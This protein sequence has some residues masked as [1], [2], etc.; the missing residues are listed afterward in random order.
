MAK[1]AFL[2]LGKGLFNE[3]SNKLLQ[4]GKE[5]LI[6]SGNEMVEKGKDVLMEEVNEKISNLSG[7]L[8]GEKSKEKS[9]SSLS[10][11]LGKNNSTPNQ[12]KQLLTS[13]PSKKIHD[14]EVVLNE[15]RYGDQFEENL[16]QGLNGL[17]T[18]FAPNNPAEAL[19]AI[20]KLVTMAGE[21]SKFTEV[22]KTKRKEIEAQRDIYV[23]KIRA[24][25]E[26][27]IV[28]L[29]KSFDERKTNFTKLFEV[30]DHAIATNNM[31]QL[32]MGLESINNLAASSPF[33]DLAS[34]ES[35]Q[36]ALT[37]DSH[38]WDF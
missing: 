29:E 25:K 7:G 13:Q 20:S 23:E 17:V 16:H 6:S 21:V 11:N 24:Q 33:K 18:S 12:E 34:I 26:I 4:Q 10:E 28:Y 37:D 27:M 32:S 22:Q 38:V 14:A 9:S 3:I 35:T 8:F 15:D 2:N 36:K 1:N 5:M 19:M 30:V 31:Q